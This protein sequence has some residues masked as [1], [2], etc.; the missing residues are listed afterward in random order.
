MQGFMSGT[1][2]L[3]TA[4]LAMSAATVSLSGAAAVLTVSLAAYCVYHYYNQE[5]VWARLPE[6]IQ[7]AS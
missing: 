2:K 7:I 6:T 4:R 1:G 5:P 3:S